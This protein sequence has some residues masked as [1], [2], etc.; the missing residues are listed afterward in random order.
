MQHRLLCG[1]SCGQPIRLQQ[2][3]PAQEIVKH[4]ALDRTLY[5]NGLKDFRP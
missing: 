2:E 1:L 4:L 3:K 5:G